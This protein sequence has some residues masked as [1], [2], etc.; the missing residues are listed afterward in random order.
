MRRFYLAFGVAALTV[1]TLAEAQGWQFAGSRQQ[2]IPADVRQSPGG[3]RSF[4]F[5]HAGWQGGK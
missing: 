3:Y 4:H 2:V 5:W 1:Y